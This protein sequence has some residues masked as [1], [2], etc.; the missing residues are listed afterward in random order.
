M[1]VKKIK[2]NREKKYEK[3]L[4]RA[5][6]ILDFCQ[7][8]NSSEMY[9]RLAS[10]CDGA[11]TTFGVLEEINQHDI[12]LQLIYEKIYA[13]WHDAITKENEYETYLPEDTLL[14]IGYSLCL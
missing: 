9:G 14:S 4:N 10:F 2:V 11:L 1:K 8:T 3:I 5:Q 6:S 12:E 13:I 7:R